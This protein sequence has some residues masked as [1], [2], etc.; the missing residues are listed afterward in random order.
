MSCMI[1]SAL[2]TMVY[3]PFLSVNKDCMCDLCG[4]RFKQAKDVK[5]HQKAV[6]FDKYPYYC[7]R[8]GHGVSRQVYLQ[9][10]VCGRVKRQQTTEQILLCNGEGTAEEQPANPGQSQETMTMAPPAPVAMETVEELQALAPEYYPALGS[11]MAGAGSSLPSLGQALAGISETQTL[12]SMVTVAMDTAIAAS[13]PRT[14]CASVVVEQQAFQPSVVVTNTD[15]AHLAKEIELPLVSNATGNE[16]S[17]APMTNQLQN[18][19]YYP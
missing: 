9:T 6:H 16:Y 13:N 19:Y 1:F 8:C 14:D 3:V 5:K 15:G 18:F 12:N 7:P 17:N 11:N 4:K 2:F 10:H